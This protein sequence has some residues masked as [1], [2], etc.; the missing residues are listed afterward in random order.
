MYTKSV[1]KKCQMSENTIANLE[2]KIFLQKNTKKLLNRLSLIFFTN[3]E[4]FQQIIF[5]FNYL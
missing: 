4:Y 3:A 1:N 5:I 2:I